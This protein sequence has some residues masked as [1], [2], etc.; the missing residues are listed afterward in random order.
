MAAPH[1]PD[2]GRIDTPAEKPAGESVDELR[3]RAERAEGRAEAAEKLAAKGAAPK[4]PP[5]MKDQG[6]PAP[7]DMPDAATEP[8]EFKTWLTAKDVR[9]KW[10][11]QQ[12]VESVKER[13][14]NE[15]RSDR[16]VEDYVGAHPKYAG[17]REHVFRAFKEVCVEQQLTTL[18]NDTT[19][20]DKA[21]DKKM[22]AL[23]KAA[24][25]AVDDLPSGDPNQPKDETPPG[26]TEG[27]SGG[28]KGAA[29]VTDRPDEEDGI[30]IKSL[31]DVIRDNQAKSGFF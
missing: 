5:A 26:R 3:L 30:E 25:A 9:N 27:L 31:F 7:G 29:P 15:N 14:D 1:Y 16:I 17:L 28:S 2:I 20:L 12:Y 23:V 11:S 24:A 22:T 4:P 10:E 21:V 19:A 13:A 18:P 6:P 8:D